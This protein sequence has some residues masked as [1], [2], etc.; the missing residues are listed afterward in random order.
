MSK[1]NDPTMLKGDYKLLHDWATRRDEEAFR[2]LIDRHG[3][4]LTGIARR[5]LSEPDLA[6]DIAGRAFAL[7]SS[8]W[9]KV[10]K[11][12]VAGWLVKVTLHLSNAENRAFHRRAKRESKAN[13]EFIRNQNAMRPTEELPA[14][15]DDALLALSA[16]EREC[17]LLHAAE[18][19][20]HREVADR[21]GLTED[22]ARMRTNRAIDRV[23]RRLGLSAS[24][25]MPL[26]DQWKVVSLS[27][28]EHGQIV[29][30]AIAAP[31]ASMGSLALGWLLMTDTQRNV[32]VLG[33]ALLLVGGIGTA[34]QAQNQK[35]TPRESFVKPDFNAFVGKWKG[36]LTY[37]VRR[38]GRKVK[39]D[40]LSDI[41][42]MPNGLRFRVNYDDPN[43]AVDAKVQ[44]MPSTNE[45]IYED[46]SVRQIYRLT[47]TAKDRFSGQ[48]FVD[49]PG[50]PRDERITFSREPILIRV[51]IEEKLQNTYW[52]FANEHKLEATR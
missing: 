49:E 8:K 6:P 45:L 34:I 10:P 17:L 47:T 35:A 4:L 20:T 52:M 24:G 5:R 7:L 14:K 32:I 41:K 43:W 26:L 28:S 27:P 13:A 23:R 50:R 22:A 9:S 19:L 16:S 15:I 48:R 18:G 31:T 1:G 11:D 38:T 42:T 40:A 44:V 37:V 29:Q 25:I 39:L 36:S 51:L 3:A 2:L 21:L 30:T 33:I 12:E 46:K